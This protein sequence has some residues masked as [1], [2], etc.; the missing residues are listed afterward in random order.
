MSLESVVHLNAG[1][2]AA[3]PS[4]S[5]GGFGFTSLSSAVLRLSGSAPQGFGDTELAPRF[6]AS[7][8]ES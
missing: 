4:S 2:G 5:S 6:V 8:L 1:V 3:R 7:A